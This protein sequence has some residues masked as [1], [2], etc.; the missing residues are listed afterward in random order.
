MK[1]LIKK[2]KFV[3][4]LAG[5]IVFTSCVNNP[6]IVSELGIQVTHSLAINVVQSTGNKITRYLRQVFAPQKEGR[7]IV[8]KNE[9][10]GRNRMAMPITI[11][12]SGARLVSSD[13][14]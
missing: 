1:T 8:R 5:I 14:R 2:L 12:V 13:S 10:T 9:K 4:M 6:A 7:F 3:V 11:G